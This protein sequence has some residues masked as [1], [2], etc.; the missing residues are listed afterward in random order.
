MKL[1]VQND[2]LEVVRVD[3]FNCIYGNGICLLRNNKALINKLDTAGFLNI[4]DYKRGR[5]L[6]STP[7]P[8]NT[9][10]SGFDEQVQRSIYMNTFVTTSPDATK[11]AYGVCYSEQYGFGRIEHDSLLIDKEYV[12]SDM[13]ILDIIDGY[14]L[15]ADDSRANATDA[16]GTDN[17]AVFLYS[18]AGYASDDVGVGKDVLVYSWDGT[19]VVHLV[20]DKK[21]NSIAYDKDRKKLLCLSHIPE[22]LYIEYDLNGII[23]L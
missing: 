8:E 6:S 14:I 10:L 9:V 18:G 22:S 4:V 7:F 15:P 20:L 17:F 12:Y 23:D 3:P 16:I 21:V 1:D 2:S 5:V 11:F 19:P 13:K